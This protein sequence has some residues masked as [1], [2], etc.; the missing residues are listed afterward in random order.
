MLNS[1]LKLVGRGIFRLLWSAS[2][3][4]PL[5]RSGTVNDLGV[6]GSEESIL[7]RCFGEG[8]KI[9]INGFVNNPKTCMIQRSIIT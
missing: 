5:P 1:I 7:M 9:L 2:D 3:S 6:D 4:C 8:S